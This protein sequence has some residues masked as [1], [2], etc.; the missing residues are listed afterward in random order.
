MK[1]LDV[2]SDISGAISGIFIA[3]ILMIMCCEVFAR[4]LFSSPILGS[5]EIC[6]YLYVAA[7]YMGLCYTQKYKGHIAVELLYD[8]V[9]EKAK[10]IM[11]V[12]SYL[13]SDVMFA[14]FTIFTWKAFFNSYSIKETFL[15]AMEMPVYVL[16]FMI[17]LGITIMFFQL[18]F[19]TIEL[20]AKQKGKE[21]I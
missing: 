6:T 15:A 14:F 18:L 12:M 21:S 11:D 10:F 8:R 3:I 1:K 9:G 17:A 4:K 7:S 16:K 20:F 19:D 5:G 2:I 13:I